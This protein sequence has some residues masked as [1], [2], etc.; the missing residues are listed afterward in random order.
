MRRILE[1]DTRG[2]GATRT[3]VH[4]MANDL[5]A[6]RRKEP[7]G[8]CWVDRFTKR[9]PEIKLRRSRPYDRQRALNEDARVI[10]P[11]FKLVE[12][13]K[14]KYGILD[15]DT[16]NFDETG[17]M[18]GVIK[19]QM[20]FT[21]S[22]KRSNPKRIQPGSREWVTIIQ[23]I[24]AAGWAIPPFVIFGGKILISDWYPG[25]P[26][27]WVITVSPNGWT[28][29]ELAIKWLKHFDAHT[30]A[31]TQGVYRL[32]IIDGHESHNSHEFHKYCEEQKIIVLCMPPH[33]SHLLQPLDVGCFSPLKRAYSD[34]I[35]SWAR[36]SVEQVKK[37]T[38]L[39]AFKTAF[40]KAIIRENILASFRGAGLVPHDP[41]RVLSKLDVVLRTPT[42]PP[43]EATPWESKT[44]SN[45]LEIEA[46]STLVRE[47]IRQH[48]S[49]PVSPLLQAV[50]QLAKGVAI[51]GHNSVLL[52]REMAGIRKAI[53]AA[54][55]RRSR[56]RKYIRTDETLTVGEVSDLIAEK[57]G[58]NGE[59]AKQPAKRVRAQRHC[60]RCGKTGHNTRT[61]SAEIVDLDDSDAPE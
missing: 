13:T 18:M 34:E 12:D 14:A 3:M 24:C 31:R 52:H 27:D 56:K 25:M 21:G 7:V 19:G 23:G 30:K 50:D 54:T 11:W 2:I 1:L 33:S 40:D 58:G 57:E 55:E 15:E 17:F 35:N 43:L 32:L 16:H 4:E 38:F 5:R 6:A 9:T 26:R 51:M 49:S 46:Q 41:E 29:N 44:P 60:G 37:T 59:E 42:P 47:R 20:V 53:E 28:S 36:Y 45:L 8:K 10:T 22:E 61:C 39:P 48:R